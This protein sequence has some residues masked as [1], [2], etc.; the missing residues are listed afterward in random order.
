MKRKQLGRKQLRRKQFGRMTLVAAAIAAAAAVST[1]RASAEL[2]VISSD[3]TPDFWR[4][5][6]ANRS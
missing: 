4:S 5:A 3:A 2:R 6:S 1:G